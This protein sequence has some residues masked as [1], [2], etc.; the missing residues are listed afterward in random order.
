LLILTYLGRLV[1]PL[2]NVTRQQTG[3]QPTGALRSA[4][5][6]TFSQNANTLRGPD[7]S[8]PIFSNAG[9]TITHDGILTLASLG[10]QSQTNKRYYSFLHIYIK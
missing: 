8:Q 1:R 2:P 6:Q 4:A 3:L 7:S 5:A 9:Q 10:T